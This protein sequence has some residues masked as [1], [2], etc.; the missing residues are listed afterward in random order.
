MQY[1]PIELEIMIKGMMFVYGIF[2]IYLIYKFFKIL[3][4]E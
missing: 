4:D 2:M 1:L 3:E